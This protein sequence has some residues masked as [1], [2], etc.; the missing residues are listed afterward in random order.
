[1]VK[2]AKAKFILF[3]HKKADGTFFTLKEKELLAEEIVTFIRND[4]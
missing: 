2:V 4:R 1:M 3:P